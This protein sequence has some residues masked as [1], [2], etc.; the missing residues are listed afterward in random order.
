MAYS[1]GEAA[2]LTLIQALSAYDADNATRQDWKPLNRGKAV[3]YVILKPGAWTTER[4]SPTGYHDYYSTI[5]EVWRRYVDDTRPALL[6]DNVDDIVVQIRKYPTLN[7]ASGVQGSDIAGG[8]EMEEVE[9]NSGSLWARWDIN[10]EWTDEVTVT[11]A[12]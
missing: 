1:T 9:L 5:I 2:I 3:V 7:G 8:S 4:I 12:E 6:Q 10:C 11:Y